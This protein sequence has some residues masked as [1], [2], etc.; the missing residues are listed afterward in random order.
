MSDTTSGDTEPEWNGTAE[1]GPSDSPRSGLKALVVGPDDDA[2]CTIYPP[3]VAA[4]YRTS[5]WITA[6]QDSFVALA[7]CR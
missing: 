2:L 6:E 5:T 4:P 1:P 7:E 3:D